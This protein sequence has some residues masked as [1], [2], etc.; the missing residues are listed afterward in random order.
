MSNTL[1]IPQ[2]NASKPKSGGGW[3]FASFLAVLGAFMISACVV[4]PSQEQA[5]QFI[6]LTVGILL[7]VG[8]IGVVIRV[9]ARRIQDTM[10]DMPVLAAGS[11]R[12]LEGSVR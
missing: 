3:P 2:H 12:E 6:I 9:N 8:S 4:Y 5:S 1:S 11:R 7:L 10:R